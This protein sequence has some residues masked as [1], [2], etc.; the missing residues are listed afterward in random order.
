MDIKQRKIYPE[1]SVSQ[2][3]L[4][5]LYPLELP[6]QDISENQSALRE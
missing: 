6:V 3:H 1:L 5:E 4:L 2:I